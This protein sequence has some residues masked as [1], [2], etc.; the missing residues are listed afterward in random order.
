MADISAVATISFSERK[1]TS[2]KRMASV[3]AGIDHKI[4][5]DANGVA[6]RL[7]GH[8]ATMAPHECRCIVAEGLR[9]TSSLFEGPNE[10]V[11]VAEF[12]Y[13]QT[14][15]LRPMNMGKLAQAGSHNS[16]KPNSIAGKDERVLTSITL[17]D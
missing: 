13:V 9:E 17:T 15:T 4:N 12:A 2:P 11:G 1:V 6:D 3:K 14:G 10:Q 16:G 7:S 5:R 8:N